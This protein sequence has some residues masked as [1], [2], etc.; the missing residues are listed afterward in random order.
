MHDLLST[1]EEHTVYANTTQQ[2]I[3]KAQ[4]GVIGAE[5]YQ[6]RLVEEI[7]GGEEIW[8]QQLEQL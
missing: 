2:K 4:N 5:S 6:D 7:A 3:P 8:D 1:F